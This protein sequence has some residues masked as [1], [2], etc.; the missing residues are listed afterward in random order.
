LPRIARAW[1]NSNRTREN[2]HWGLGALPN[3]TRW[4]DHGFRRSHEA[5]LTPIRCCKG[6]Q[7]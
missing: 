2:P 5:G 6:I 1:R 7:R 4:W 3:E